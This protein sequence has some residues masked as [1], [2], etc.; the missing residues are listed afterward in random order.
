[1]KLSYELTAHRPDGELFE[2][3]GS[4]ELSCGAL[5]LVPSLPRCTLG[6]VAAELIVP[7][8]DATRVFMNGYQTW[9]YCPEYTM[10]DSIRGID[11]LPRAIIRHYSLDRYGDYHFIPYAN[12]RGETHG[13]SW[14]C[15]RDGAKYRLFAS[16]DE[17]PGYT[18]FFYDAAASRLTVERDCT[19]VDAEGEFHA[20]DL[21]YAEGGEDEVFD[22]WFAA[23]NLRPRTT[24]KLAG[25]SSWY[26]RYQNIDEACLL[27]DLDGCKKLLRAGDM[28]QIDDGW[29]LA[30]G[31]WDVDT[32]KFP[33]GMRAVV[34]DVHAA[35]FRAGLWLAPFGAQKDSALVREH[36]DWLYT[37]E[38][39]PYLAGCNWGDYYALDI[40]NPAVCDYLQGVFD[41]VFNDWG[42]DL[43]KLD[44]LYAAALYGDA[45]ESRAGRMYRAM[46]LLRKWCGDKL[47]L[48]C[49]VPVMPAFGLVDY[50]RIS[51][52][53]SFDW[54]DKLY[55]RLIHRERV[56][57]RQAIGNTVSRRAINARAYMS[58]PDVF[59]LRDENLKLSDAR[60]DKLMYANAL[61]G[62]VLF[63]SDDPN[64][65]SPRQF[66]RYA[67]ARR[68]FDEATAHY[69]PDK[70][71][72]IYTLDGEEK[73][74]SL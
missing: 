27:R 36:P 29:E 45:R 46:E 39:Q 64:N 37:V 4:E 53:V 72:L 17:R 25:Y 38:G 57:T 73:E 33:H 41:R 62:G 47:I 21:F 68:L 66:E 24:Q 14:C 23:M 32:A 34:D 44:F 63:I 30:V 58:D 69:D 56:S 3:S 26:N 52:D 2:L 61:L 28:F 70:Q 51:C 59:F 13:F 9:T 71:A 35:G 12:R 54:D 6:R 31:D 42:F 11:R 22:A 10:R 55:M 5:H 20:F 18:V 16:L 8:D 43:V 65:Y 74:F 48:G 7:H 15:F 49:G 40:D 60:K 19:G 1:M 50:C 67:L